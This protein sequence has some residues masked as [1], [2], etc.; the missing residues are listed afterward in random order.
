[1]KNTR[2]IKS[3]TVLIAFLLVMGACV[4]T[5]LAYLIDKTDSVVNTFNPTEVSTEVKE[6]PFNHEVKTNV[7]V[8]NTG[9]IDAYIR[10]TVVVTWKNE[11]NGQVLGQLPVE[12]TDYEMTWWNSKSEDTLPDD[13]WIKG[14]DGFYYH[15]SPVGAGSST[16][17]LFTDCAPVANK[18]PEGYNLNV[19]IIAQS[20]QAEPS[21]VVTDVWETGV[22]SV[23]SSKELVVITATE[24]GTN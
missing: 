7:K 20:I 19:E 16:S 2:N 22:S 9:T 21:S 6:D 10:A 11:E 13:S 1:M 24:G 14:T 3:L 17:V 18:I 4:G 23:N 8:A 12:N 5:T 15:K